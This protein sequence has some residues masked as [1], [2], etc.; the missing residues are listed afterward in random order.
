MPGWT[1]EWERV[2]GRALPKDFYTFGGTHSPPSG[3]SNAGGGRRSHPGSAAEVRGTGRDWRAARRPIP[4]GIGP[5]VSRELCQRWDWRQ[6]YGHGLEEFH[7]VHHSTLIAL[8]GT[9]Y[10]YSA[11]IHGPC[12]SHRRPEKGPRIYFHTALTPVVVAPG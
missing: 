9:G 11:K 6:R 1:W 12:C 2:L 7:G 5:G 3:K 4:N 8:D 10:H